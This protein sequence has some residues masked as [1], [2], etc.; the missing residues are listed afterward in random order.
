[1][2]QATLEIELDLQQLSSE[3][4]KELGVAARQVLAAIELLD[5]GNTIPFIARYRK[6]ATQGLDELALRA[7][8]DGLESARELTARKN[9]ILR[10]IDEQGL[11]TDSL[12]AAILGCRD[13]KT[14][15]DLYLPYKPK[16]RTRATIARE[17]GLQPL[18]DLLL[19]QK[20]IG[21]SKN[22]LLRKFIKPMRKCPT[23]KPHCRARW[24]LLRSSGLK[25]HPHA[26]GWRRKHE[27][28]GALYLK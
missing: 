6:E 28:K 24:I 19:Q 23:R 15:E 9:T 3:I 5:A 12:R 10:T 18:A 17:R 2:N 8:E 13:S 7:I 1:M 16:R 21:Q 20:R 4:A 26:T 14:L 25:M 11:L 27:R 22:D